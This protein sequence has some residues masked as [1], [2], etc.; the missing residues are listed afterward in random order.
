M[1]AQE[2]FPEPSAPEGLPEPSAP[3]GLPDP[4][5]ERQGRSFVTPAVGFL[6][7]GVTILVPGVLLVLLG[8]S[9]VFTLGIVLVVISLPFDTVGIAGLGSARLAMTSA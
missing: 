2:G 9:W 7:I 3:E 8:S 4:Q 1:S 5:L 6:A